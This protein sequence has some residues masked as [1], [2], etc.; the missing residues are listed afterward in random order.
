VTARSLVSIAALVVAAL[1]PGLSAAAESVTLL[2]DLSATLKLLNL[3]CG[4]VVSAVHQAENDQLATCSNGQRYRV[5]VNR[6]GRVVAEL[7]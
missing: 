2:K 3:P 1:L 5:F 7:R 4:Q 6:D